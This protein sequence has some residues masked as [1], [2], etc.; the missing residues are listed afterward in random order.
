MTRTA[1]LTKFSVEALLPEGKEYEVADE[2]LPGF[3]VRVFPTGYKSYVVVFRVGRGRGC[4]QKRETLGATNK[5]ACDQARR[6]AEEIVASARLGKSLSATGHGKTCDDLFDD[7]LSLHVRVALK[8]RT[9]AEYERIV[10]KHLRPAFRGKLVKDVCLSD[11]QVL[12]SKLQ[13]TPRFAN[14]VVSV[15]GKAMTLAEQWQLRDGLQHPCKGIRRFPERTRERLLTV[16]EIK[17]IRSE[18]ATG[19][20]HPTVVLAIK[21]LMATGCRSDEICRLKWSYVDWDR[22][23]IIWPDTKT[24]AL[25]KGLNRYV[26]E[27]LS[28]APRY[29][30]NEYVC[31][32]LSGGQGHLTPDVLRPAWGKVLSRAGV[33]HCGIHALRHWFAS[34]TYANP[35]ISTTVA[36]KIVGH[37]SVQTAA[38]YAH[39]ETAQLVAHADNILDGLGFSRLP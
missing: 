7:F 15:L 17:A 31:P 4:R 29:P 28:D 18:L 14:L 1:K 19:H 22:G 13:S 38:R 11:V 2:R 24:G 5:I 27:L 3:R 35:A 21:L 30:G 23:E 6:R 33:R 32:P 39:V 10:A 16:G 36:M 9:V 34:A 8:P 25:V 12:H 20:H 26:K 37:K